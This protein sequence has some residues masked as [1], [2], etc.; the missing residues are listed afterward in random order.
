MPSRSIADV[1][2]KLLRVF[3]TIVE[4]DGFSQ[5]QSELNLSRSTISTHMANL[6]T[7]VG[8][9]LC[10]RG[11]AGFALTARGGAVYE[12]SRAMLSSI[13]AYHGQIVQLKEGIVGEVAIGVVDN[14]ITNTECRLRDAIRDALA[15]HKGLRIVLR[16]GPPD[17]VE[18]QLVRGQTQMAISPKFPTRRN[19]SQSTLFIEKQR[20]I[21][22]KGHPLF[23]VPDD[24]MTRELIAEQDFVRRGFVSVLTP[25][26]TFFN[27]PALAVSHQMEGLAH[28]IL[29]GN[30]VGFLPEVYANYWVD[31]QEMRIIRADQFGF[32]VPI[33]LS[34][35]EG[36][37]HS[38][39]ESHVY[40][41]ILKVHGATV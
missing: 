6:E 27:R 13:D 40:E 9:K 10:S 22:G 41:T 19:V 26:S 30:C 11:R 35:H 21:C 16:I 34:R 12:A 17:Q 7:R 31:R 36:A 32:D 24:E 18:E 14:L 1:D 5:A 2:V 38:L 28:F 39:A 37:Q 3:C 15:A 29:S 8:F 25:Y 20:L 4:C 33:C 23:T